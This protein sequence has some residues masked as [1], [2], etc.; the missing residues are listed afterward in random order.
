MYQNVPVE[1]IYNCKIETAEKK[2]KLTQIVPI[3]N[4]I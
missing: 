1:C 2:P 3:H 4:F